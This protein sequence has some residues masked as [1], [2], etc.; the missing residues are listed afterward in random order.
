VKKWVKKDSSFATG[1]SGRVSAN[2]QR[3]NDAAAKDKAAKDRQ[4]KQL[5][6]MKKVD[7]KDRR[8]G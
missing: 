5:A 3:Q 1:S 8:R 7:P 2:I 6:R 4:D